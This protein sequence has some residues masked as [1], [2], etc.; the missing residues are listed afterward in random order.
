MGWRSDLGVFVVS[1]C[2]GVTESY[3]QLMRCCLVS[4]SFDGVREDGGRTAVGRGRTH[5]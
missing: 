4:A 2:F 1:G 3:A 5:V